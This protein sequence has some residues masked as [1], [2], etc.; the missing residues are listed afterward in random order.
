VEANG[1]EHGKENGKVK[2]NGKSH[3][4]TTPIS[5]G[6]PSTDSTPSSNKKN[7][8]FK[9]VTDEDE[10]LLKQ[11]FADNSFES[12]R[13]DEWGK[14]ANEILSQVKGKGFRHEKTKKKKG[15]YRG[16]SIDVGVNSVKFKYD[17]E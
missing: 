2:E 5:N 12:K 3:A 7:T 9:R 15:T 8:P 17:E 14:K 6:I 10:Q 11:Q 13:G 1:V 16:G 4:P